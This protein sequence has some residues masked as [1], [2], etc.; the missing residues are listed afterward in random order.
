MGQTSSNDIVIEKY[1]HLPFMTIEDV[2]QIKNC[3][4]YLNPKNGIVELSKLNDDLDIPLYMQDIIQD[5]KAT[6][7]DI[8][9]NDFFKIMKPRVLAMKSLPDDSVIM[10]NT[11]TSVF[12]VICPYKVPHEI[13]T[14]K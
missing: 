5:M 12:C 7:S 3:F 14:G 6:N 4:E 10:E 9:F 8:S 2:Y 11:A 1:V 13:K